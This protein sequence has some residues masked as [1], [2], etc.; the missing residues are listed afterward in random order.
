M[1]IK[2][3][4]PSSNEAKDF[5]RF[6]ENIYPKDRWV[7][8]QSLLEDLFKGSHILSHHFDFKAY[9]GYV[10]GR[11]VI[12]GA[13]IYYPNQ[14]DAYFGFFE[15]DNQ[16]EYMDE[17]M[18]YLGKQAGLRG[19]KRIVGPIQ[20]SFWLGYRM[21]LTQFDKEPFT[22]EPD[23]PAY[24]PQLWQGAGFKIIETYVSNYYRAPDTS[25][26]SDKLLDR[27]R[28]FVFDQVRIIHPQPQKWQL[29]FT[30]IY[31]LLSELYADFPFY[32]PIRKEEFMD[33]FM[34]LAKVIHWDKITLAYYYNRLVGFMITIPDYGLLLEQELSLKNLY[35]IF[36]RKSKPDQFIMMYL[37]VSPDFL[38][39][40]SALIYPLV[41]QF[42]KE[43]LST[44]SAL[45]HQPKVTQ[46]YQA[47]I[48]TDQ[49][50]YGMFAWD[51]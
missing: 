30:D 22:G 9:I 20:A 26:Q 31:Y 32:Y 25:Y 13:M 47:D 35:K 14:E 3:V 40:G 48:R 21:K 38:G 51:L 4:R 12:R 11:P 17:F 43:E 39:L 16:Q 36:K 33:L 45:I 15:A 5:I 18:S 19:Y 34:P 24:Y 23:N 46:N 2:H 6:V 42:V 49:T 8:N 10:S 7:K 27:Y 1:E 28:S 29:Y 41:N 44:I 37:G 50:H